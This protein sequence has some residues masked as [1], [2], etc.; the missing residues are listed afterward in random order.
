MILLGAKLLSDTSRHMSPYIGAKNH[1]RSSPINR[2]TSLLMWKQLD[3]S[4]DRVSR[5]FKYS[6]IKTFLLF[7]FFHFDK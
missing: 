7:L 1:V 3:E 5:T 4:I 2:H 6:I